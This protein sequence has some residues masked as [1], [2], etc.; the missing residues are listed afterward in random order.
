MDDNYKDWHKRSYEKETW[1]KET[2]KHNCHCN[3]CETSRGCKKCKQQ[4]VE[5]A[6]KLTIMEIID[7]LRK[8]RGTVAS[9][10]EERL[11]LKNQLTDLDIKIIFA[12]KEA[13]RIQQMLNR[14]IEDEINNG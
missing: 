11:Q 7:L 2:E 10:S 8:A 12:D 6:P 13:V 4:K 1:N 9:L 5:H 14:A 3:K